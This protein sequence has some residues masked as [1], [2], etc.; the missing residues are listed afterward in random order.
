V[1]TITYSNQV[2]LME[3]HCQHAESRWQKKVCFDEI[4]GPAAY[5][6]H[7]VLT[8]INW[9]AE[10]SVFNVRTVVQ[11]RRP[12]PAGRQTVMY[13]Q[14]QRHSSEC[15]NSKLAFAEIQLPV[16]VVAQ[17][18]AA[19]PD[20]PLEFDVW[21]ELAVSDASMEEIRSMF[22]SADDNGKLDVFVEGVCGD[23]P[24]DTTIFMTGLHGLDGRA[25]IA[26]V[27]LDGG[28]VHNEWTV[29]SIVS[30]INDPG[31]NVAVFGGSSYEK[32]YIM[33]QRPTGISNK[34]GTGEIIVKEYAEYSGGLRHKYFPK[35]VTDP[36]IDA[37]T[38]DTIGSRC[39]SYIESL[40]NSQFGLHAAGWSPWTQRFHELLAT[41]T[42]PVILSP[43]LVLPY[44]ELIDHSQ[45]SVR[46]LTESKLEDIA[47]YLQSLPASSIQQKRLNLPYALR[48]QSWETRPDPNMCNAFRL[49]IVSVS[50]RIPKVASTMTREWA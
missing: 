5:M 47:G 25:K 9:S 40:A 26:T 39:N 7:I 10:T 4:V 30:V 23:C 34:N 50:R 18:Q 35:W 49:F 43:D 46:V 48:M 11:I 20:K 16:D 14:I 27:S 41:A 15:G 29:P 36:R 1:P 13:V 38:W 32:K 2:V 45:Y 31:A 22:N 17:S 12:F 28:Y 8:A 42:I 33:Y 3:R 19:T 44:E 6:V 21:S 37:F 24:H